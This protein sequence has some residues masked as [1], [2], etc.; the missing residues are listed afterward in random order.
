MTIA[1]EIEQAR[2]KAGLLYVLAAYTATEDDWRA[3]RE[4]AA[5]YQ[6]RAADL[7]WR[8][9]WDAQRTSVDDIDAKPVGDDVTRAG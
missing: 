5:R 7:A 3:L 8:Q 4:R 1:E 9:F 2:G 6:A